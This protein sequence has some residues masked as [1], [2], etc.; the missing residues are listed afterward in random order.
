MHS[1]DKPPVLAELT[2]ARREQ[3]MARFRV[4]RSHIEGGVPLTRAAE[5]AGLRLRT[6]E[7]WLAR[8]R[9][10]GL[11]GLVRQTR[12]DRERRKL[13]AEA[14]ELIEGLFLKKPRPSAAALHRRVL[15]LCKKSASGRRSPTAAC[16]QSSS[17]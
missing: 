3:A 7:R 11:A 4:L 10:D 1:G 6:A 17:A 8:Y 12:E 2:D 14:V 5:A 9:A 15:T 13:P 16:T